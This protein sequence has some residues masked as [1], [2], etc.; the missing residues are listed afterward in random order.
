MKTNWVVLAEDTSD[1]PIG[2]FE[3][4]EDAESFAALWNYAYPPPEYPLFYV[5]EYND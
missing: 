3:D 4:L 2:E 1:Y 5:K